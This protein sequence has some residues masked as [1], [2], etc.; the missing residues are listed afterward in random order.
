MGSKSP[1][2]HQQAPN[3]GSSSAFKPTDPE[4]GLRRNGSQ[5]A[6]LDRGIVGEGGD[7]DDDDATSPGLGCWL[8]SSTTAQKSKRR[9]KKCSKAKKTATWQ[10]TSPPSVLVSSL[11]P[12]GNYTK[13]Q[14]IPYKNLKRTTNEETRYDS[15]EWDEGFL[16][17]YRQAA[18][19]H[20]QVRQYV[21]RDVIK[22]GVRMSVI[23]EEIDAGVRTLCGH[24]GLESGDPLIAGLAFPTGLSV[25]HVAAHWTPNPGGPDPV[26]DSKDVI[27]VDFGVHVNGR[28]VDSAFT[29]AHDPTYDNLLDAVKAATNT[30]LAVSTILP[31]KW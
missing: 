31:P 4:N 23:A 24:Q 19:I 12:D 6:D 21:Q 25:N 14:L 20:R 18:E 9:K 10:Q 8:N 11:F 17:D 22:P 3:S 28:I 30:G 5:S 26:L 7:D 1:E 16:S 29:V 27:S 2:D 13:G 15:R